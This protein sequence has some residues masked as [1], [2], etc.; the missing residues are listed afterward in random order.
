MSSAMDANN[1]HPAFDWLRFSGQ[2][3]ENE[4]ACVSARSGGTS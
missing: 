3:A 2:P 1:N 4:I